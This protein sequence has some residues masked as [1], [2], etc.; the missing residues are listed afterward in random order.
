LKPE[1]ILHCIPNMAGGGAERQLVYLCEG[2][3]REG[4]DVHVALCGGG[5]N[6]ERLKS[7]GA[8][9]HE[10][11]S[12]GN[13]DI[14]ILRQL[15]KLIKEINPDLIQTWL[16]QMDVFGGLAAVITGTPFILSERNSSMAYN[17]SW[18]HFLR[19]CVVKRAAAIIANSNDGRR[20]WEHKSSQ[21]VKKK[22]IRNIIPFNEIERA[23]SDGFEIDFD[24]KVK[25]IVFAGRLKPQKNLFTLLQALQMV[26]A[27]SNDTVA[28]LFGE[29]SLQDEL[30]EFQQ[31][32]KIQE[33]LKIMG[34]T[35][36]LYS[37]LKRADVFVSI[38]HYEGNPNTVLEA[39]ACKCP[40][41]AS[42]ISS[43]REFLDEN[44]AYFVGP[45]PIDVAEG[46]CNALSHT[47]ETASKVDSAYK[48]I[49]N[50]STESAVREYIKTY[51]EIIGEN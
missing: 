36:R 42:D 14:G 18:K 25:L 20:Y 50:F 3:I 12:R 34:F 30:L 29:G 2:L 23:A 6:M 37:W 49:A 1:T 22:V 35:S 45:S 9:I 21:R 11:A 24:P 40:V 44:C 19:V 33:R 43:H 10:L 5:R 28:L 46:I 51:R 39:I 15:I 47:E 26:F 38:S 4:L 27:K 31:E 41:V 17:R 13:H 8:N 32:L 16:R 48:R 7:T